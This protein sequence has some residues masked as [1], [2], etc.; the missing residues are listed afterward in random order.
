M[1]GVAA[2][3]TPAFSSMCADADKTLFASI[4]T[5]SHHVLHELL[6]PVAPR[7]YN[8]RPRAHNYVLPQ[9]TS[10]LADKNYM[11]RMLYNGVATC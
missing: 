4:R 2:P 6:P 5:D 10:S 3:A 8:L 7:T 11:T 9:R 1:W